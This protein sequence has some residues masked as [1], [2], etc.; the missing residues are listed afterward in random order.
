MRGKK[1]Q[2]YWDAMLAET[3]ARQPRFFP[4][5]LADAKF[6]ATARGELAT[7]RNRP[8]ALL[9]AL[10]LMWESDAFL[11]LALYRAQARLGALGVPVLPR[12]AHRLAMITAQ[13]CIGKTVVMQPGVHLGHGQVVIDGF[14]E[15]HSGVVIHPWVT[16]GLRGGNYRGPTI[17]QDV[18]IGTGAKILGNVTVHRDARIGANS[19]VVT[20]VPAHATA[21][22]VP[23]R[24][25]PR[26]GK[27]QQ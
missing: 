19:V 1:G 17:E 10:R 22:G 9:H 15:I 26:D 11:A 24:I 21:I 20:D 8:H 13:V 5:V 2:P 14:V 23:A 3:G 16:I 25:I 27:Q 18:R 7:F 4:A 6:A 12:L